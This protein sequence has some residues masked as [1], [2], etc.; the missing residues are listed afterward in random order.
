MKSPNSKRKGFNT[1]GDSKGGE[2]GD[3]KYHPIWNACI[4]S[5]LRMMLE[6][7]SDKLIRGLT[8][9]V[10]SMSPRMYVKFFIFLFV[11]YSRSL[12]QVRL[13]ISHL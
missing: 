12:P 13:T 1:E 3:I 4:G 8:V 2:F 5:Q 11:V 7:S 6:N 9:K 10:Y